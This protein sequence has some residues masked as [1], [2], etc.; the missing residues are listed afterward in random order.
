MSEFSKYTLIVFVLLLS[1][2]T[3]VSG[4]AQTRLELQDPK[5]YTLALWNDFLQKEG[6]A[7]QVEQ[8]TQSALELLK[9]NNLSHVKITISQTPNDHLTDDGHVALSFT[10]F[11]EED[12][13]LVIAKRITHLFGIHLNSPP[14]SP[15]WEAQVDYGEKLRGKKHLRL[16]D[17]ISTKEFKEHSLRFR[18]LENQDGLIVPVE[19]EPALLAFLEGNHQ[20]DPIEEVPL[21]RLLN[22]IELQI[23]GSLIKDIKFNELD[24]ERTMMIGKCLT[25]FLIWSLFDQRLKLIKNGWLRKPARILTFIGGFF[26]IDGAIDGAVEASGL[27]A[28]V[29]NLEER[30]KYENVLLFLTKSLE[31]AKL[32]V[33]NTEQF[34]RDFCT[35]LGLDLDTVN[36]LHL[37]DEEAEWAAEISGKLT[38]YYSKKTKALKNYLEKVESWLDRIARAKKIKDPGTGLF[39]YELPP[40]TPSQLEQASDTVFKGGALVMAGEYAYTKLYKM[41]RLLYSGR[42]FGGVALSALTIN[43]LLGVS[44]QES[45]TL[46][47]DQKMKLE[48]ELL[49]LQKRLPQLIHTY[50]LLSQKI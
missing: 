33:L 36:D 1:W 31:E 48:S 25:S 23:T 10:A 46:P 43:Y 41:K 45:I 28:N 24:N 20:N 18:I 30:A 22:S 9:K 7:A 16:E 37:F 3:C 44:A 40:R 49:A 21:G 14:K 19:K 26:V 38:E 47:E 15:S 12:A 32:G 2:G 17:F 5:V 42:L 6:M 34:R 4:L 39:S 50:E 29:R 27:D 13:P 8:V 35:K 11:I